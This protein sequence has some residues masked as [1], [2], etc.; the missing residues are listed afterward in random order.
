MRQMIRAITGSR[1]EAKKSAPPARVESTGSGDTPALLPEIARC[2]G[3]L[4]LRSVMPGA[5]LIRAGNRTFALGFPEDVVKVWTQAG[6]EPDAW[7]IPDIRTAHGI[8]QWALEGPFHSALRAMATR[9]VK[10]KIKVVVRREVW[11]AVVDSLRLSYPGPTPKELEKAGVAAEL[12][13]RL[14]VE[15]DFLAGELQAAEGRTEEVQDLLDPVFFDSEGVAETLGLCIRSHGSNIYSFL[16][17]ADR[18]EEHRLEPA[19]QFHPPYTAA[20]QPA[21]TPVMPERFEVMILGAGNGVDPGGPPTS[22]AIQAS[23]RFIL[24]DA[25]PYTQAVL[26]HAGLSLQQIDVL[27]LTHAHEEQAIGLNALLR[28]RHRLRLFLTKETALAVRRKLAIFNPELDAPDRILDDVFDITYVEPGRDYEL[29]GLSLRFHYALHTASCVAPELSMWEGGRKRRVL[30]LA[31]HAPRA[32][33]EKAVATGIVSAPRAEELRS[34]Y[35]FAGDLL[36]ADAGGVNL[37]GLAA[38]QAKSPAG[39]LVFANATNLGETDRCLYTLAEPGHRY[40]IISDRSR[41]TALERGM[42]ERALSEAFAATSLDW[43]NALLDAAAAENL[44]P[45]QVVIRQG[46]ENTDV[47]VLLTGELGAF[48]ACQQPGSPARVADLHPGDVFGEMASIRRLGRSA[49]IV[50]QTPARVLRIPGQLFATFARDAELVTSLPEIWEKRARLERAGV[51]AEASV[52]VRNRLARAAVRRSIEP[53]STLIREGSQSDTVFVL[54]AGRVQIYR[55][56]EPLLVSGAPII[57]GPG[58]LLGETAPFLRQARNASI[59][60]LDECE[61]LAIRGADFKRIVEASPQ[62]F[63]AISALVKER[64]AR[65]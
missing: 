29:L 62:L 11:P 21:T 58:S 20:M 64:R 22:M 23:G 8:V 7:I 12:V 10:E 2:G 15:A 26:A 35:S 27:I 19:S 38:D 9:P 30:L 36:V 60:T 52:A 50:A 56:S 25:G 3:S 45:G 6:V 1:A 33:V 44:N 5:D 48:Q 61:V 4:S 24:V 32:A 39:T 53:G 42:A 40:A 17:A 47:F 16:T 51:L 43:H 55:G 46:A 14:R 37:H 28:L 49:S 63:C 54:S 59:V 65:A 13:R 34:Y 57:L 31:H 18:I 41:P